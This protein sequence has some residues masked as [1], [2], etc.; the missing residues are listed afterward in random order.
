MVGMIRKLFSKKDNYY[1]QLEEEQTGEAEQQQRIQSQRQQ[2]QTDNQQPQSQSSSN[3][4]QQQ[5][6][7]QSVPQQTASFQNNG[8][9]P[10]EQLKG[11]TFATNYLMPKVTPF[12]RRPGANMENYKE[13]ARQVNVGSN[14]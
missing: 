7:P 5:S 12:R 2:T 10:S 8:Q 6:K 3:S 4:A 14:Q 9:G 13:L 11:E 1:I